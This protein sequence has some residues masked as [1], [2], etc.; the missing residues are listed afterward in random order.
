MN[1]I[2]WLKSGG[3]ILIGYDNDGEPMYTVSNGEMLVFILTV[4]FGTIGVAVL[5]GV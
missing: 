1:P 5:I 4:I 2:K 3:G